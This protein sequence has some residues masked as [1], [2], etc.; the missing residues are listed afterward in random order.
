MA[1]FDIKKLLQSVVKHGASDLHLVVGREPIVRQHGSLLSAGDPHLTPS[2][3][4][5]LADLTKTV[6]DQV[7]MLIKESGEGLDEGVGKVKGLG[8]GFV[9]IMKHSE[10]I[11]VMIEENSKAL[12]DVMNAHL[13]IK[14]GLAGVDMAIHAVLDVSNNLRSMTEKLSSAFSWLEEVLKIEQEVP[15]IPLILEINPD[16]EMIKKLEKVED[17]TTFTDMAWLLLDTAKLS[18]GLEPKDKTA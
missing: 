17:D 7:N 8:E 14:D 18:E 9:E 16:H 12:E 13:E 10:S 11:R 5:K 2:E 3:I 4:R 1:D 15:E 6:S